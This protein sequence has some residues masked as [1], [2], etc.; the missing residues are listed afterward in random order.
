VAAV[1]RIAVGIAL[2]LF[3][4]SSLAGG[5]QLSVV[6]DDDS[7]T[8]LWAFDHDFSSDSAFGR[9]SQRSHRGKSPLTS[10]RAVDRPAPAIDSLSQ[11]FIDPCR[12]SSVY[13]QINV[14]RI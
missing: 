2:V 3:F 7:R 11:R 10:L 12:R 13:Q 4:C 8:S 14:Y 9:R 5:E 6:L 1:Q